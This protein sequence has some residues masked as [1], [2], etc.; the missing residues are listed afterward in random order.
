LDKVVARLNI[1][2]YRKKLTEEKDPDRRNMLV[3]LMADE[4][5]KLASLE[6]KAGNNR[7]Q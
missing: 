4:E 7:N 2:H 1:E 3:R 6:K 5:A